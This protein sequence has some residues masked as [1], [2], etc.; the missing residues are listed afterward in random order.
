METL[1]ENTE[2]PSFR[3]SHS[4]LTSMSSA[5]SSSWPKGSMSKT[6]VSVVSSYSL[7]F[8]KRLQLIT[9]AKT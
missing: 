9:P 6:V 5:E 2:Y 7:F 1:F 4:A 3:L 8:I